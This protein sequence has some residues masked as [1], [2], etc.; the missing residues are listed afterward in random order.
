LR[1]EVRFRAAQTGTFATVLET[2]GVDTAH[3]PPVA[4]AFL[5]TGVPGIL[6]M[7]QAVGI[8]A[9]HTEI[10]ALVERY[11]GELEGEPPSGG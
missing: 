9:G 4:M 2:Y 8:S 6:F 3:F 11:L 1:A 7:E 5:M 10:V